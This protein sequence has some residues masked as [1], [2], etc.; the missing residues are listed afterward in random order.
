MW[1]LSCLFIIFLGLSAPG[2][3]QEVGVATESQPLGPLPMKRFARKIEP[4]LAGQPQRLQPYVDFFRR[5]LVSDARLFAF[6]V[7]AEPKSGSQ[8]ELRGY[9]EFPETHR[10]LVNLLEVLGFEVVDRLESLP[11][12]SL[13]EKRFG[14]VMAPHSLAYDRPSGRRGIVTD[15]LLGEPSTHRGQANAA[16][17][18]DSTRRPRSRPAT[19]SASRQRPDPSVARRRARSRSTAEVPTSSAGATYPSLQRQAIASPAGPC[20]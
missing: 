2:Q 10:A 9:V 1:R 7:V 14:F 6:D 13:G 17:P 15:C 12:E 20:C 5:E 8:I 18:G 11:A 19:R 16:Q 4:D 3:A